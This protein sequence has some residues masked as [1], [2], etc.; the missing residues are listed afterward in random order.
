MTSSLKLKGNIK[1][2]TWDRSL[3]EAELFN[4]E[5]LLTPVCFS[6]AAIEPMQNLTTTDEPLSID[7]LQICVSNRILL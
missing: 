6:S 3:H 1:C 7:I 5:A 4:F 2:V